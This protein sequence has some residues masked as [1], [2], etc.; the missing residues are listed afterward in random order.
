M[1]AKAAR[2]LH[3]EKAVELGY[4]APFKILEAFHE[5]HIPQSNRAIV[6]TAPA[7]L[8]ILSAVTQP[9]PHSSAATILDMKELLIMTRM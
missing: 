7:T 8:K 4:V 5:S 9:Y 2:T 3:H 1:V 6:S